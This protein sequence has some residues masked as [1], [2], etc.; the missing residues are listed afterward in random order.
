MKLVEL[1][2]EH[3]GRGNGKAVEAVL[4][5]SPDLLAEWM[6]ERRI[7]SP[8]NVWRLHF[9]AERTGSRFGPSSFPTIKYVFD[10]PETTPLEGVD[11]FANV[12]RLFSVG[13]T[14]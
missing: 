2:D 14:K 4:L 5:S 13:G 3:F 11:R 9:A 8:A 1:M 7:I 12:S 6:L 10:D